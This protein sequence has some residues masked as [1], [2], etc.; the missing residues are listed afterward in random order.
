MAL[1]ETPQQQLEWERQHRRRAAIA[2][3]LAGILLFASQVAQALLAGD[4]PSPSFLEALQRGARPG[5]IGD[6]PSLQIPLAQYLSDHL[7]WLLVT[8]AC[9]ALGAFALAYALTFLAAAT[10]ARRAA[11][12]KI[13][14][15]LPVVGGVLVGVAA[16]G[17]GVGRALD[18]NA[19]LDSSRTVADAKDIGL[20]GLSLVSEV[21]SYPAT[22][23]LAA[24]IVMVSLQA[25]RA[26]L[27]TRFLGVLG[28]IVGIMQVLQI[29]PLVLVQCYWLISL[30]VLF[31]GKRPG[32]ELPAWR[33]GREEP[34]PTQ[35]E[36]AAAR[37]GEPEP[38][39]EPVAA[40]A[41]PSPA[42]SKRKRKRRR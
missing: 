24:G 16:V 8:F 14:L 26:G 9:E 29:I 33:T 31:A 41:G 10:R 40:T 30:A 1:P 27:L 38:R 36:L 2:A 5:D 35:A 32:G 25:M 19:F 15:Y 20:G 34:W 18:V 7:G 13:A 11:F 23:A 6:L 39:A 21:V 22:L 42:G 3:A 12:P 4:A 28:I 17:R 37:K